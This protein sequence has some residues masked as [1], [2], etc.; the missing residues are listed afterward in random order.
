MPGGLRKTGIAGT[1]GIVSYSHTGD[2]RTSRV[3]ALQAEIFVVG[4]AG[5]FVAWTNVLLR[6]RGRR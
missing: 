2:L 5:L 6:Q 4:Y 1:V 3:T